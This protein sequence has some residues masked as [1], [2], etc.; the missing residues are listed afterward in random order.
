MSAIRNPTERFSSRV[1]NYVRYRP[2]YPPAAIELL[3]SRC[4]LKPGALVADIGS[5]TGI[6]TQLLLEAGAE[7]VA[8]EP[9]EPMR[10]AAEAQLGTQARFRSVSG[11]AEA[12]TL[13]QSSVELLLAAQAFHWFNVERARAEAL[14]VIRPGGIGALLWNQHPSTASAFLGDYETLVRAHASEYDQVVNSRADE[15]SMRAYFGG[16]MECAAFANQQVFDYPG[17]VGRLMSSSYAPEPGA[18]GHESLLKGLRAIFERH[19][20][21]DR[22]IF[23]YVTL[24]YYAQLKPAR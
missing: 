4:G 3:K 6:L 9:N 24:V 17:L 8:V 16:S 18:P 20:H 12:T 14:R 10:A 1:E 21:A 15:A 11:S 19:A 5:G 23:P 7:V 2:S 13:A 22:V